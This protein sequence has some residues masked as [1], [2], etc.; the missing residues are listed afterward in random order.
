MCQKWRFLS[1]I[2]FLRRFRFLTWFKE[3]RA[4]ASVYPIRSIFN[5]HEGPM[6]VVY[7]ARTLFT[8]WAALHVLVSYYLFHSLWS[9]TLSGKYNRQSQ[10]LFGTTFIRVFHLSFGC[11]METL[12]PEH[13]E[14]C[15]IVTWVV[16]KMLY[17]WQHL[18]SW[19]LYNASRSAFGEKRIALACPC[20]FA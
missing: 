8:W 16:R 5:T 7:F 1:P 17:S 18:L 11:R 20:P 14:Q 15:S 10:S 19:A 9:L 4:K 6:N 3:T 13:S 2:L 12:W